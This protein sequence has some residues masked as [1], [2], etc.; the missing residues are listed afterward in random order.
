MEIYLASKNA[1]S[2]WDSASCQSSADIAFERASIGRNN[3]CYRTTLD[4]SI[5]QSHCTSPVTVVLHVSLDGNLDCL[6][7]LYFA[8]I[9]SFF[10]HSYRNSVDNTREFLQSTDD[11]EDPTFDAMSQRFSWYC[12]CLQPTFD[13][14][15]VLHTVFLSVLL[16]WW[17]YSSFL[18]FLDSFFE[19]IAMPESNLLID[20]RLVV[21]V[22][23]NKNIQN[24]NVIVFVENCRLHP[25]VV[26]LLGF[27]SNT[28]II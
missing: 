13:V 11:I 7:L 3:F 22:W 10:K 24:K 2:P 17:F 20:R 16:L 4:S 27:Q 14:V 6:P 9:R 25:Q 18:F 21:K 12:R 15:T 19:T 5:R 8:K 23:D 26:D 1:L 28:R